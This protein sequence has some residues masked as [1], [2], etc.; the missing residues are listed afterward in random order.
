[1]VLN[2]ASGG[3]GETASQ[4]DVTI[5]NGTASDDILTGDSGD[6]VLT[7]G[8][9]DNLLT[10]GGGDDTFVIGSGDTGISTITDFDLGDVLDLSDILVDAAQDQIVFADVAG[11]TEI[12][13]TTG[14]IETAVAM[15]QNI[16]AA[17]L[18]LD[19]DGNVTVV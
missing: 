9:G 17:G 3:T 10:G 19:A 8:D 1:M 6:N 7:G 5:F 16:S 12:R 4:P 15:I 11:D 13:S 14:G 2:V 18:S